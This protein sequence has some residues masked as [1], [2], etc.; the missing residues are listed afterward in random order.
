MRNKNLGYLRERQDTEHFSLGVV[1]FFSQIARPSGI[2]LR[3]LM[4]N[5]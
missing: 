2:H 4:V 1:V 3:Y 5:Q